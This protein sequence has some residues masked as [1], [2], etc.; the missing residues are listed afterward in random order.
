MAGRNVVIGV[1]GSIAAYKAC[2]LV[3]LFVKDDANVHVV[4]TAN[5]LNFITPLTFQTLSRNPVLT[6]HFAPPANW[7]PQ[8]ISLASQ[9]DLVVIAPCTANV[10]AKIACGIADDA[11]T[12]IV[13]A[14]KAPVFLAPAMN[15]AMWTNPA[16][17]AN[18]RT[19][20]SR[21]IRFVNMD[22][23]DLACGASGQGRMAEPEE[24][25]NQASSLID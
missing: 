16:T 1:T 24:I 10:M 14:A 11:L 21:G 9:A 22:E 3:R 18:Y 23:G 13:L 12:S 6:D 19:L 4:M 20:L 15:T 17:Q 2:S 25:F 8:H 7:M 5:A